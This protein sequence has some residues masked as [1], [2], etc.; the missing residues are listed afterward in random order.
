MTNANSEM[1]EFHYSLVQFDCD[2]TLITNKSMAQIWNGKGAGVFT[3]FLVKPSCL[4]IYFEDIKTKKYH[5]QCLK[6]D[7][8][9]KRLKIVVF[10]CS[11]IF[12]IS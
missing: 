10:A 4:F 7:I 1:S 6:L 2:N 5:I 3:F 12:Y 8:L 9:D 11:I